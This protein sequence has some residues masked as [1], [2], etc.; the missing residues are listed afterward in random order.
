LSESIDVARALVVLLELGL[1]EQVQVEPDDVRLGGRQVERH[2][3]RVTRQVDHPAARQDRDEA[4]ET[5]D[6]AR[7]GVV[8]P[9]DLRDA[10]RRRRE[11]AEPELELARMAELL[12]LEVLGQQGLSEPPVD[13]AQRPRARGAGGGHG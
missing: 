12:A 7:E 3:A 10:P 4:S 13:A 1:G 6:P 9:L 5:N 8:V 2:T 11:L